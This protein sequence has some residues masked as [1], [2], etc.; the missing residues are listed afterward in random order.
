MSTVRR[1]LSGIQPT[2]ELHLG[3]Y[4]GA[5]SNWT[6]LQ[7]ECARANTLVAATTTP[8]LTTPPSLTSSCVF[9]IADLHAITMPQ[10]PADLR[11]SRLHMAAAMLAA[12]IDPAVSTV[13]V[14]SQVRSAGTIVFSRA[15]CYICC[16]FVA[17]N[18]QL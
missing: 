16:L 14:Q 3:N 18:A 1:V 5:L 6:R 13:F 8:S 9:M 12:G 15:A 17:S 10:Q 7:R 4:L 11:A 2:G